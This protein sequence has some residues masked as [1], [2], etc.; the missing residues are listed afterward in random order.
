MT[1]EG[2]DV[3]AGASRMRLGIVGCALGALA[4]SASAAA[5][6]T[7]TDCYTSG[8]NT[9]CRSITP[10]PGGIDVDFGLLNQAPPRDAMAESI[11]AFEQGRQQAAERAARKRNIEVGQEIENGRCEEARNIALRAGDLDLAARVAALCPV[12]AGS[13]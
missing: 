4:L 2:G 9:H 5:Q 7:T 13:R 11:R 10:Q 8:D 3:V 12:P 6:T 1:T